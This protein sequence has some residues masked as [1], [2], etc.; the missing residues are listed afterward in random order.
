MIMSHQ[1]DEINREVQEEIRR[2]IRGELRCDRFSRILYSTD[3]SIY[4]IEPLGVVIP[5]STEDVLAVCEVALKY[6]IPLLPR[7]SG[8]SLAGQTVG[9]ALIIDFSRHLDQIL[10]INAEEMWARVQPGVVLDHLNAALASKKLLFGPDTATSN[11]ATIGG[12]VGNNSAGARSIIYKKTQENILGLSAILADGR[13]HNFSSLTPDELAAHCH[14]NQFENKLL[15]SVATLAQKH[16]EEILRRYPKI[17]RRVSGYNLDA[18]VNTT[19]I[20]LADL[21]VGSEGTLGVVTEAKVKLVPRPAHRIL[22]IGHFHSLMA[23]L[24]AVEHILPHQ[25]SAVELLD[26]MILQLTKATLE[27]RRKMTFVQD[28]P[29]ALL[30]VELQGDDEG[31]LLRR[32]EKLKDDMQTRHIG[33]AWL[34]ALTSEAQANVWTVRKAGLGLLAGVP[35]DRKPIAFVEDAAVPVNQMPQFINEFTRII[36]AHDTEAGI[37]AH[38]SV[39][40]LHIKPLINLKLKSEVAKMRRLAEDVLEL[41]LKFGGAMSGEHGDGLARSEW[42]RRLFGDEIYGAF[43]EIKNV[44]DPDNLFNPGKIVDA[45]AMHENLRYGEAY[46]AHE[47]ATIFH[48]KQEGGFSA[49][50]ELCNGNGA[51]RKLTDGTMCPSFMVTREEEHSTRGRANLLRA[52]ISGNL[53]FDT[54]QDQRLYDA[55]DLCLACKGC[56]GE[57]PTNVDMAKLKYEFLNNYHR[58]HGVPLR[59]LLFGHIAKINRWVAPFAKGMNPLLQAYPVKWALEKTLDIDRRRQMPLY[60]AQT[61]IKWFEEHQRA[62]KNSAQTPGGVPLK[63]VILFVDTFTN[64][65]QPE[66]GRAAVAVLERLGFL[67]ELAQ[68]KCCGRPHLSKGLLN[69]ARRLAEENVQILYPHVAAGVPIIGLEPSCLLTLRDEYLDLCPGREAEAIAAQS[70]LWE[71]F[72]LQDE[73]AADL[74]RTFSQLKTDHWPLT[75]NKLLLHGHCHQKAHVGIEKLLTLLRMIPGAEVRAINSGCCGMAGAFGFEK[76]HYDISMAIGEQ[77]LFP[78]IREADENWLVVAPGIS[79]RQQIAQG[80]G[81]KVLHPAEVMEILYR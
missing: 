48:Y 63:K 26:E 69:D 16:R 19:Q 3:A 7:G 47:P 8:T 79:C 4:Q 28:E 2:R 71:E 13:Q 20:N 61:F 53:P 65:H 23:A 81:R 15:T 27:F 10:E 30:I 67:V 58:T 72:L 45:P 21:L 31:E 11:R 17:M 22:T 52:A 73:V 42:H 14:L 57:C 38:A 37:Y 1:D 60:A 51:C 29:K 6:K 49:A 77:R 41:V 78:A 66:V 76:E 36:R 68:H 70:F 59:S 12:M 5:K 25:P 46:H 54:L 18:F 39:G 55:L 9:R 56:K 35:G 62:R 44:F 50:V 33:F 75:T 24:E 34:D 80:T 32:L 43:K 40:C 64:Y 74:K